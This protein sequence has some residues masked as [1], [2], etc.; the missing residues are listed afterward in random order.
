M[1]RTDRAHLRYYTGRFGMK[2]KIETKQLWIHK[3]EVNQQYGGPE[4]GGWW[5]ESGT[6]ATDWTPIRV[7]IDVNDDEPA[8]EIC[9]ALNKAEYLRQN[10][11][12]D[13]EFTSVLSYK[14]RHFTY[15]IS[16]ESQPE[17]YPKERP[18]YE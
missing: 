12:E 15:T 10:Y 2:T 13:Y 16:E 4:E 18:H 17:A 11:E 1:G 6:P 14:S 3:Y 9:R 8:Y 7:L 5:F